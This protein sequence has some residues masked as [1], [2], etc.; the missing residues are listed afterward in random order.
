MRH[1]LNI[2]RLLTILILTL[3]VACTDPPNKSILVLKYSEFGSQVIAH[4]IIGYEWWQWQAHG[5]SRPSDYDVEVVVYQG[6]TLDTVKKLYPISQRENKDYRY[7][8]YEKAMYY[9]DLKI[10]EN[11]LDEVTQK[12]KKTRLKLM[13][14]LDS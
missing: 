3:L 14:E 12:L 2:H 7:L 4:E 6:E 13:N 1:K 8:E 11:T 5:K 10:N 9:L